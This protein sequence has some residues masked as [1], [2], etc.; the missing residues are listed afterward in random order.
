MHLARARLSTFWRP[1]VAGSPKGYLSLKFQNY[2]EFTEVIKAVPRLK[3]KTTLR[4]PPAQ[5]RRL[6][7]TAE[8]AGGSQE[9]AH[10][11]DEPFRVELLERLSP[12]R[13]RLHCHRLCAPRSK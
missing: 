2:G 9:T 10:D 7:K 11:L 12:P 5:R 13:L 8:V 6:N 3:A 4:A 1:S